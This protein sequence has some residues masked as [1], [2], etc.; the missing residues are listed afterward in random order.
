MS[1]PLIT[2]PAG[3]TLS[4]LPDATAAQAAAEELGSSGV[5]ADDLILLAG[6]EARDQMSRLGT[7]SGVAGRIRRSMQF[8]T[9]DQMPDLHVYELALDKGH[10]LVGVRIVDAE[11]RRAAVGV[12]QRHG[13]HF[14]NRFG[15]WATEEISPW[16]G[17]MLDLPQHLHR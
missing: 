12:L 17:E 13:A 9:M 10:A 15:D 14:I 4:V 11:H 8:L 5:R 1:R 3:W 16:R 6:P 2:Y 7:S